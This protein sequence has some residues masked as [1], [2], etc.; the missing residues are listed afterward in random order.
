ME[1]LWI[2]E[3][4]Q[5]PNPDDLQEGD[6]PGKPETRKEIWDYLRA[7]GKLAP[8]PNKLSADT[9]ATKFGETGNQ[10]T[11]N[12][13]EEFFATTEK[14][15]E[16]EIKKLEAPFTVE[17]ARHALK[18]M[19]KAGAPD[20]HGLVIY[21]FTLLDDDALKNLMDVGYK[22]ISERK[23]K[24]EWGEL[25]RVM[26]AALFKGA[27]ENYA[28]N[29]EDPLEDPDLY[30]FLS[31]GSALLKIFAKIITLRIE[32]MTEKKMCY[33]GKTQF[34]FTRGK[35]CIDAMLVLNRM[36]EDLHF[37]DGCENTKV[38]HATLVDLR[39]AFPSLNQKTIDAFA[40][41]VG[42][43]E[44][45]IYD[46]IKSVHREAQYEFCK[47]GK[48][49]TTRTINGLKEGCVGSPKMFLWV[50]GGV[51][52]KFREERKNRGHGEGI[53]LKVNPNLLITDRKEAIRQLRWADAEFGTLTT[54]VGDI[55]FADDTT[56]LEEVE[57]GEA[58]DLNTAQGLPA[59]QA[60]RSTL[61][62]A[63]MK[64]NP[65]KTKGGLLDSIN[66]KNLGCLTD[67][68]KDTEKKIEKGWK[69]YWT[70]KSKLFGVGKLTW[71][72]RAMI[73]M[74]M[75]RSTLTY[76]TSAR[77]ISKQEIETLSR[78]EMLMLFD[79]FSLN[80]I[81]MKAIGLNTSD[82]RFQCKLATMYNAIFYLKSAYFAHI[83]R[84][85][86][87]DIVKQAL[88][89][90]F[91]PSM[92]SKGSDW[93]QLHDARDFPGHRK[94]AAKEATILG[95]VVNWLT[96][97]AKIPRSRILSLASSRDKDTKS[98]YYAL[99]REA[100]IRDMMNDYRKAKK[101]TPEQLNQRKEWLCK[102]HNVTNM[103][104]DTWVTL[105]PINVQKY[106]ELV[107]KVPHSWNP[108]F[109][110]SE[111]YRHAE[112]YEVEKECE[113][114]TK[115]IEILVDHKLIEVSTS[116]SWRCDK[117]D[118]VF[119]TT[120]DAMA[121]HSETHARSDPIKIYKTTGSGVFRP[122]EHQWNSNTGKYFEGSDANLNEVRVPDQMR[123]GDDLICPKCRVYRKNFEAA[124][125][126]RGQATRVGH[127]MS[128]IRDCNGVPLELMEVD[129][130]DVPAVAHT[131]AGTQISEA[132]SVAPIATA[133]RPKAIPKGKAKA[134]AAVAKQTTSRPK[135]AVA[136]QMPGRNLTCPN[137]L[138]FQRF[139]TEDERVQHLPKCDYRDGAL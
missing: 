41:R 59:V 136:K 114:V 125:S 62:N 58:I 39:K 87:D 121:R 74:M 15:N 56:V 4:I 3:D 139:R 100:Y 48:T 105:W 97:K 123:D 122:Q 104:L 13:P 9:M 31:I 85:D 128:H 19:K 90:R 33:F 83:L 23:N 89:G 66:E 70:L 53:M 138:C 63:D 27:P 49:A 57:R 6:G 108:E 60:Y 93:E 8:K 65:T 135:A 115:E 120:I 18:N 119:H 11:K 17:E 22:E 61:G 134:K 95:D 44:S 82:L 88:L 112:N 126:A 116:K 133:S 124:K 26:C 25:H 10:E 109:Y 94:Y 24:E 77:G 80:Q 37:Y 69:K 52:Q 113:S 107:E 78:Q 36:Q 47:D 30:R 21:I 29:F 42:I 102:K 43:G 117:C 92:T 98:L 35:S 32:D 110:P 46:F 38:C 5:P 103:E 45:F 64:E 127:F 111:T 86:N 75:C 1:K 131:P 137:R 72:D 2:V 14:L 51:M 96:K 7:I 34:G 84:K 81:K 132:K 76:G 68:A 20:V 130:E 28:G 71:E 73:I 55:E 16:E 101:V 67:K 54:Y 106:Q 40:D 12:P 99:C 91:F 79:Q 118:L 129:E 50:Y